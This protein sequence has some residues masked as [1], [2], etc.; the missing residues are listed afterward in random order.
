MCRLLYVAI[1]RVMGYTYAI[2]GTYKKL[3]MIE[4]DK[5]TAK[6]GHELLL[7]PKWSNYLRLKCINA[8]Y[9]KARKFCEI[10]PLLL[11]VCT[12][13]KS[14]GKIL[15]NFVA[16]SEYMNFNLGMIWLDSGLLT[17]SWGISNC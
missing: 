12:V 5:N 15:Q 17:W 1:D 4:I 13:V 2:F 7:Q 9:I 6:H 8:R 3:N 11:T 14:E 16:F 10:F